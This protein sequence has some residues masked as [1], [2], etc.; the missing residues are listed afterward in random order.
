MRI[1]TQTMN[2]TAKRA[3]L[4]L[5]NTSLLNYINNNNSGSIVG[6]RNKN[7]GMEM[8]SSNLFQ[9]LET[10]ATGL[11][12]SAKKLTEK[13]ESIFDEARESGSN[14]KLVDEVDR[15]AKYFN[16]TMSSATGTNSALNIYYKKMMAQAA[17][18]HKEELEAIGVSV[19]GDGK[20]DVNTDRLGRAD[21]NQIERVFG[22]GSDFMKRATAL[23]QKLSDSAGAGAASLASQYGATG[24]PHSAYAAN[25][26]DYFG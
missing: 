3:H 17:Q 8:L 1:P 12:Q 18:E 10:N 23:A 4:P 5:G 9:R 22:A 14:A 6:S 24:A 21:V 26:Y 19:A 16:S 25:R 15:F 13:E 20:L 7:P 11:S 2:E